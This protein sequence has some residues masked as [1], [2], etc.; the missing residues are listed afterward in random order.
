VNRRLE[1]LRALK[2][3]LD[4]AFRVP[5]TNVR[6]GWDPL[7]GLIPWAGDALTALFGIGVILQAHHMRVPKVVQLRMMFNLAFD[8][9]LGVVPFL[10]DAVDFI[11]KANTKNFDLLERHARLHS[12]AEASFG[13]QADVSSATTGDWVFV[14]TVIAVIAAVALIPPFV[15]YWVLNATGPHLPAVAR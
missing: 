11:W 1:S 8:L 5:G 13:R 15:L 3:L 14:I 6:F 2:R 12:Q 10:G 9:L 7:I 4:E